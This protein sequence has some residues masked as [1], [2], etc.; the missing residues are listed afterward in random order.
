MYARLV[1]I[2]VA[3]G[4]MEECV[5]IFR[6]RNAPSIAARRGFDHGDWFVDRATGKAI[7]VTFWTNE[8]DERASR[9]HIPLLIQGMAHVLATHEIRQETFETVHEQRH[10][11]GRS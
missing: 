5:A 9:A 2:Q 1:E 3:P 4:K 11:P 10:G 7:S 6:D 8:A